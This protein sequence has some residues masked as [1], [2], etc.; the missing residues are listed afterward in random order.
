MN[1][2]VRLSILKAT[3]LEQGIWKMKAKFVL[4]KRAL[5]VLLILIL[6]SVSVSMAAPSFDN[7]LSPGVGYDPLNAAEQQRA[8]NMALGNAGG[9]SGGMAKVIPLVTAWMPSALATARLSIS[10]PAGRLPSIWSVSV[11][12]TCLPA[13]SVGHFA[14]MVFPPSLADCC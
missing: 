14:V 2:P 8:L 13:A 3:A 6:G 1:L 9:V 10:A 5:I 12:V 4:R 11:N 7:S